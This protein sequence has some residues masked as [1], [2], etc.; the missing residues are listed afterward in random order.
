MCRVDV[1]T[2]EWLTQV[3]QTGT[4]VY[5]GPSPLLGIPSVSL[6]LSLLVVVCIYGLL[7]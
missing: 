4:G 1:E 2:R 5:P 3:S 7:V 6:G